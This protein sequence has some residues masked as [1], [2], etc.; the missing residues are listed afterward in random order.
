MTPDAELLDACSALL[1]AHGARPVPKADPT[2]RFVP[3]VPF[4]NCPDCGCLTT[5]HGA[6]GECHALFPECRCGREP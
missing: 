6:T 1:E 3:N 4:E 2:F 5:E